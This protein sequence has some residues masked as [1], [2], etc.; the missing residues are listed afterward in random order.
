M[1]STV[2]RRRRTLGFHCAMLGVNLLPVITRQ[3]LTAIVKWVHTS[4]FPLTHQ[5]EMDETNMASMSMLLIKAC[6]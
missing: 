6:S 4:H 3:P 2:P 5:L 1:L